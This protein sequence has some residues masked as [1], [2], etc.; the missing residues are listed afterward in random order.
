ML[1]TLLLV[2]AL[3]IGA[4]LVA[5]ASTAPL[6]AVVIIVSGIWAVAKVNWQIAPEGAASTPQV[7]VN[8]SPVGGEIPRARPGSMLDR[9]ASSIR[10]AGHA[11]P[12]VV[13]KVPGGVRTL[14]LA[15]AP[16]LLVAGCTGS[17]KSVWL[18][19][20]IRSLRASVPAQRLRLVF[21]DPKRVELSR[22]AKGPHSAALATDKTTAAQVL[23]SICDEMDR[24]Y[25][26]MQ[27]EGLLQYGGSRIVCII[28]EFADLILPHDQTRE[29]RDMSQRLRGYLSRLLALG[30]AAGI[31]LVLATQRPDRNVV[32]GLMKANVPTRIAF[33]V[34]GK[35]ESRIILDRNGAEELAGQG[36]G[37]CRDAA[38]NEFTFQGI[39]LPEEV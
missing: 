39:M 7:R 13:G 30:R 36:A 9:L 28:D 37:I 10:R 35:V 19:T 34:S 23:S 20:M 38:G 24:R 6:G 31:H 27:K 21:I 1:R 14:D 16:H 22:F 26:S 8:L 32:D 4:L 3:F 15:K 18:A 33:R 11:L 29:Q 25:E 17:G 5:T 12:V 2:P